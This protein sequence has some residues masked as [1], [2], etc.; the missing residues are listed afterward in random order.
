MEQYGL[1]GYPLKHSFSKNFFANK[2]QR[3]HIEAEYINFEIADISKFPE[4]IHTHPLLKGLN[5]TIPYKERVIPFL[6]ELSPEAE[7]IGAVNVIRIT[8]NDG[9]PYLK[10]FNADIIGFK[11][12]IQ[13]LLLPQ[14][15]H[16]LILGT[17]GASK[18]V[19]HGLQQLGLHVCYVSRTP[20]AGMVGYEELTAEMMNQYLVIVNC[21]PCGM[22][23]HTEA[24]PQI[25]YH[26]LTPDHLLYDLIYNPEETLFLQKGKQQG[27]LIKNGLEM[28]HLQA[29][30]SWD[31]WHS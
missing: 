24:C 3:E 27:C 31:F 1:L 6:N 20:R 18:A 15:E 11:N 17:G 21:T 12:S 26:Q 19:Y 23:P 28:L 29:E 9:Q 25:P 7:A 22:F 10:G 4:I 13:P 14:H 2:F 30:A 16:A 8:Q 5:V